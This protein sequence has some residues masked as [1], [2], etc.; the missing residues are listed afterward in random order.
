M[1]VSN[2][3][4][5]HFFKNRSCIYEV[6]LAAELPCKEIKYS[7]HGCSFI[8]RT[9]EATFLI[10]EKW[11]CFGSLVVDLLATSGTLNTGSPGKRQTLACMSQTADFMVC[12]LVKGGG[13]KSSGRNAF[14]GGVPEV[15]PP[16]CL[17]YFIRIT[18]LTFFFSPF[19]AAAFFLSTRCKK[20]HYRNMS[21]Y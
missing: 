9:S 17:F 10:L 14:L 16:P 4:Q 19:K 15:I 6:D 1:R 12:C 11:E 20:P 21:Q 18:H 8:G 3:C 13:I 7:N 2:F 5:C